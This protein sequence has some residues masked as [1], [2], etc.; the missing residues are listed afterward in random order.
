MD[1]NLVS[2]PFTG[3]LRQTNELSIKRKTKRMD[4]EILVQ[5]HLEDIQ[6]IYRSIHADA[7]PCNVKLYRST[8]WKVAYEDRKS[9]HLMGYI[10]GITSLPTF[11]VKLFHFVIQDH[12]LNGVRSAFS[13][14]RDATLA[15]HL[16]MKLL[17][18]HGYLV[19]SY[20]TDN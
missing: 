6:N 5:F 17:K 14:P 16:I 20:S 18:E 11:Y 1:F 19:V 10:G 9:H 15:Y 2:C 4:I 3:K 12:H 7:Q 8:N 13:D